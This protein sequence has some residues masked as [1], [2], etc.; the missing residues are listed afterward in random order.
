MAA[1][2]VR[3]QNHSVIKININIDVSLQMILTMAFMMET[4]EGRIC[5]A[6]FME[7][8]FLSFKAKNCQFC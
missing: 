4:S 3:C 8:K 6:G 2:Y 1:I 7:N 5:Y